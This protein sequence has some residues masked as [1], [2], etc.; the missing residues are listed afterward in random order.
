M[1]LFEY[2]EHAAFYFL[3][4]CFSG[5]ATKDELNEAARDVL[6]ASAKLREASA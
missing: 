3:L 1:N 6:W 5:V 2:F 4:L